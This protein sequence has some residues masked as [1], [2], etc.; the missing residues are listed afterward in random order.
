MQERSITERE[1]EG[2]LDDPIEVIETR[3]A[4]HAALGRPSK[5]DKFIVVVFEGSGEDFIVVT[6]LKIDGERAKRYGFTR[7]R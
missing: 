3:Y 4:R 2:I 5:G 1:A 7:V 6:A